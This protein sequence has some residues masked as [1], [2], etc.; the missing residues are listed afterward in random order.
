M[1][2]AMVA[3]INKESE[4]KVVEKRWCDKFE[5]EAVKIVDAQHDKHVGRPPN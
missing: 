5:L 4:F 1:C 2:S 3:D